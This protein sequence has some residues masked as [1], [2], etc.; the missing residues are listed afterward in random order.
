MY[1]T[2]T[3]K[4]IRM[5]ENNNNAGMSELLKDMI[6]ADI[7]SKQKKAMKEGVKYY[8]GEHDISKHDFT[9]S[10]VD[11]IVIA[12]SL[13]SNDHVVHSF[14]RLLVDQKSAYIAGNPI[15]I[16]SDNEAEA[17]AVA[18]LLGHEFDSTLYELV[19]NVSNKGVEYLH[20]YI[21][22][23]GNFKVM[24]IDASEIIPIYDTQFQ[25]TLVAVIRYYPLD[26]KETKDKAT[27]ILYRVELW[28]END[29]TFY[30]QDESGKFI[31]EAVL[32]SQGNA[33]ANPKGHFKVE[34]TLDKSVT[35]KGWN[36]VPFIEVKNNKIKQSDLSLIK[37]MIDNYDFHVSDFSNNLK[38]IQEMF[39]Q[40]YGAGNTDLSEFVRNLKKYKAVKLP[41][42]A[43]LKT[44]E[45]D[46]P[47]DAREKHLDRL[48]EDIFVFGLGVDMNSDKFGNAPSGI[49][50][51]FM[52]SGLDLKAN[53]LIREL[54]TALA[55]LIWFIS[56]Y[57]K[58]KSENVSI[59]PKGFSFQ[60]D[61]QMIFN[62]YELVQ[63]CQLSKDVI[64]DETI[65]ENHP[66]VKD[67]ALE[68]ERLD[69]QT[70]NEMNLLPTGITEE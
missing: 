22:E 42:G 2:E 59:N 41:T 9:T 6:Q 58:L 29:V 10:K 54:T 63:M 23:E 57:A 36:K 19:T 4:V 55:T 50:L 51:K 25:R 8:E 67:S 44:E 14:H 24:L 64:S 16:Q 61:K 12:N 38:D 15:K 21:D 35:Q 60:F 39:Y 18:D 27:Q 53:A 48:R 52:Y 28:S 47:T 62:D 65:A 17:D 33:V 30:V 5:M 37:T 70:A 43:V 32:D 3:Q 13:L 56:E 68:R 31:K 11:G 7:N 45:G 1:I 66:F 46:I 26:V 49:A 69:E 40:L 20:T 34:N